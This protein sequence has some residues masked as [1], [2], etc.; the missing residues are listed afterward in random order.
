MKSI[1]R[2]MMGVLASVVILLTLAGCPV[3][4]FRLHLKNTGTTNTIVGV[5]LVPQNSTDPGWGANVLN[6]DPATGQPIPLAPG[7][8]VWLERE[9]IAGPTY[10]WMVQFENA[11]GSPENLPLGPVTESGNQLI[12]EQGIWTSPSVS[13]ISAFASL[14][15]GFDGIPNYS[16][17]YNWGPPQE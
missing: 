2:V 6:A 3:P 4:K 10:D 16:I 15:E 7:Q 17:G 13:E 8:G 1:V 5:Y 9:F 11:V 12:F 14:E